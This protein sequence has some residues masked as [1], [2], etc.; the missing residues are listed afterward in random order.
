MPD[1]RDYDI[2]HCETHQ[3]AF[4]TCFRLRIHRNDM[5]PMGYRELWEVFQAACPGKWGV[6]YFPP[7][8]KL[9][10]QANKYHIMVFETAPEGLDMMA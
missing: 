6:Q 2:L 3:T 9:L 1:L 7:W 8:E 10:D 4:G 5:L